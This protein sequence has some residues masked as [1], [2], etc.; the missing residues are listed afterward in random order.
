M[1]Y[2]LDVIHILPHFLK[3]IDT[4]FQ[5]QVK[6]IQSDGSCEFVTHSLKEYFASKWLIH[7]ISYPRTQEKN[8]LAER[9]HR[10]IVEI[11]LSLMAH[12]SMLHKFWTTAF[13]TF[14]FLINRL[15]AKILHGKSP[16]EI[17]F[18]S[19]PSYTTLRIFGCACYLHLSPFSRSKHDFKYNCCVFL[20]Y[21]QQHKGHVVWTSNLAKCIF[22]DMFFSMKLF[23][24][25]STHK[26]MSPKSRPLFCFRILPVGLQKVNDTPTT[27]DHFQHFQRTKPPWINL[28]QYHPSLHPS[29]MIK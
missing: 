29:L 23:F 7:Q 21:S 24:S 2:K 11:G 1:A 16:Y 8:G 28:L 6:I 14:I 27:I 18:K 13:A 26:A 3:I 4:Q 10:H 15:P 5:T 22:W 25:F 12:S 9:R 20:R 17:V 19:P